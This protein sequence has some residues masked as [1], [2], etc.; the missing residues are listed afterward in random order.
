MPQ[1]LALTLCTAFVI[2]LLWLDRKQYPEASLSLWIP[3]LWFLLATSK[4]LALWFGIRGGSSE[5]GSAIDR[6][7][8]ILL[9]CLCLFIIKK[10]NVKIIDSLKQNPSLSLL[11]GFTLISISW[12]DIPF[13]SFKRWIRSFIPFVMA[14]II[15]SETDPQQAL[16]CLFRRMI[17][18]SIPFSYMLINFYPHLGR[19]YGRWSGKL[20]W[21]G[22]STQK[23][24]L[25]FLCMLSLF[26]FLWTFLRRWQGRDNPIVWYLTYIEIFIV[27]LT[28]WLF[29]GPNHTLTYSAT[30]MASLTVGLI[31]LIGLLSLKR[32]NTIIRANALT[33]LIVAIISYGTVTPFIGR[34]T[35]FDPSAALNRNETLTGRSQIW[36]SLIPYAMQKPILGHGYGGFWTDARR[37]SDEFP[38]HNGYLDTILNTGFAGLIFLSMFLISNCRKAQKLMTN[39][40][41]WGILWF[42]ILI[43]A[44]THNISE[45]S[46]TSLDDPLP[47]ILLIML[48]SLSS[49]FSKQ[50][51]LPKMKHFLN[52]YPSR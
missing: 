27:F 52:N 29:M 47:A 32:H 49:K 3:T 30:S 44:V 12:S 36:A 19:Q 17:Y 16:Q 14:L 45:S 31:S 4:P 9:L 34:L 10:R 43:I 25:A 21:I 20:M 46:T 11:I 39:D 1:I 23:N 15:A 50:A 28:I 7:V 5:E 24:G 18:I 48:I 40:F 42:C 41:D 33:M 13:V 26:Y 22:V 37:E 51:E 8:L 6:S 38:S 2:Y 35:L